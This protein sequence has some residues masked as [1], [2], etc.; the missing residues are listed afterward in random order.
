MNKET[1]AALVSTNKDLA[2]AMHDMLLQ[3]Y[4]SQTLVKALLTVLAQDAERLPALA[5]EISQLAETG[6]G[7]ALGCAMADD[8]L[9]ERNSVIR[10][11]L[12]EAL[13]ACVVLPDV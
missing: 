6:H 13:R 2:R 9:R 3:L 11:M 1:L 5:R 7:V 4:A 8:H 12:P 10:G